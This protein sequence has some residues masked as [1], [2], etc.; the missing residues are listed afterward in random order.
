MLSAHLNGKHD[1][2]D[3]SAEP[4]HELDAEGLAAI[5][6]QLLASGA[7]VEIVIRA[8][9]GQTPPVAPAPN[10]TETVTE[11][12]TESEQDIL[13]VCQTPLCCKQIAAKLGRP[14]NPYLRGQIRSLWRRGL[15][16]NTPD[17]YH[18]VEN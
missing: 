16:E 10:V 13:R 12:V 15:L 1:R 5:S 14:C 6:G 8:T 11:T 7:S 17:G 2:F 18:T 4:K 9:L 3:L